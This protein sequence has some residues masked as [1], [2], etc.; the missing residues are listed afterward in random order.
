MDEICNEILFDIREVFSLK[1]PT[2]VVALGDYPIAYPGLT[3]IHG[4][5]GVGKSWAVV[6]MLSQCSY[7]LVFYLDA[8]GNSKSFK[9]H[10]DSNSVTYVNF[11]GDKRLDKFFSIVG[12]RGKKIAVIIDSFSMINNVA[13]NE[14]E[15]I[16]MILSRYKE[17]AIENNISIIVIDHSR[18]VYFDRNK[19][20]VEVRGGDNKKKFYDVVVCAKDFNKD[21]FD[22]EFEVEKSRL[23]MFNTGHTFRINGLVVD[24]D[25][26]FIELLKKKNLIGANKKGVL[27]KLSQ[28][29]RDYFK[30]QLN[31]YY[32]F[33][34]SHNIER[35][36]NED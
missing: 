11:V 28:K 12:N 25:E 27:I 5:S 23:S 3:L 9:E 15:K 10:C 19:Y 22:V 13:V 26:E 4:L 21:T 7:D 30:E 35:I 8:E 36:S 1:E 32:A 18:K 20:I 16:D 29:Q 31:N 24:K 33:I 17:Q 34:R 6:S 2:E 14:T